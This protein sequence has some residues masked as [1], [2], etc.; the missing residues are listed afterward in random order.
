MGKKLKVQRRGRGTPTFR[1]KKTHKVAPI[2]Y[3]TLNGSYNG[4]VRDLYHE[5]GRGAPLVYVELEA[6]GGV[7]A[8]APEGI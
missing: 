6:G 5:P 2:K 8:A 4:V 1:A 3:P 7:Y